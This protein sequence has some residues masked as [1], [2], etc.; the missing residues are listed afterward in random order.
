MKH[1]IVSFAIFAA[2]AAP[3]YGPADT[4]V[5]NVSHSADYSE[6][7][8]P[9]SVNPV[10]PDQM[11]TVA[12]VFQASLPPPLDLVFGGGGAQDTRV[13]STQDGGRHWKTAKLD[14]GGIGTLALPLPESEG[15]SPE[16][17]DAFN[18]VNTDADSIWDRHGNAYF[19][20]GDIHG[21]HHNGDETATVWRSSDGG[22]TWGP[23]DG[24]RAVSAAAEHSELDRPWFAIDNSGGPRDGTVYM[25]FE[26]SP[27]VDI[28]PQVFLKR[29]TDHGQTWSETLRVDD[30]TY[31][32]QYNPRAR[33]VV[34][35][36][37]AL[38]VVYDR[39][40][41]A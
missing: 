19:E 30:G 15:R 4:G 9:L 31:E 24:Y 29:S 33:P 27:F 26:T 11:T 38:Y 7:E 17:S 28:P 25:S 20:S 3:T 23:P 14:Q 36:G 39:S 12:N 1:V 21:I 40:A 13:Y 16:F 35:A 8:E 32:T 2:L 18:I 34:G 10:D 22:R 41:P 6:G 37:G 5:V